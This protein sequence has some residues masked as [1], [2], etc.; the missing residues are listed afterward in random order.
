MKFQKPWRHGFKPLKETANLVALATLIVA[1]VLTFDKWLLISG[2]FL[3]AVFLVL[4][5]QPKLYEAR[6]AIREREKPG[7]VEA[8]D[9]CLFVVTTAG[10]SVY[11]ATTTVGMPVGYTSTGTTADLREVVCTVTNAAATK[12]YETQ[13]TLL[14]FGG[15]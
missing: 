11:T 2:L 9:L 3:E 10:A 7:G 12:T 15:F 8:L 13:R 5:A 4:A 6:L 1:S 14:S